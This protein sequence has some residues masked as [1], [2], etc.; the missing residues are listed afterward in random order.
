[1]NLHTIAIT[2]TTQVIR[3]IFKTLL[4]PIVPNIL[5]T[6]QRKQKKNSKHT[7]QAELNAACFFLTQAFRHRKPINNHLISV[8]K[9]VNNNNSSN[10][11]QKTTRKFNE[12]PQTFAFHQ[13]HLF[14]MIMSRNCMLSYK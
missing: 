13:F 6:F 4:C 7:F 11:K 1:M 9:T 3:N 12:K 5:E 14:L 10:N 8:N 2:N